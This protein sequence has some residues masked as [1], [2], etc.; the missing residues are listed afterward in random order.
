M[1]GRAYVEV[2]EGFETPRALGASD[3][4][5]R[6]RLA[7]P[8]PLAAAPGGPDRDSVRRT[9]EAV[10]ADPRRVRRGGLRRRLRTPSGRGPVRRRDLRAV[11]R[12]GRRPQALRD[13]L[14]SV[15]LCPA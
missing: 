9:G 6:A 13:Q 2:R 5:R 3:V 8:L 14:R 12:R 4:L 1:G 15:A 7:V 10:E 11:P